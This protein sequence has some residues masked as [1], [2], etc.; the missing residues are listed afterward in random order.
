MCTNRLSYHRVNQETQLLIYF[1]NRLL[2]TRLAYQLA[3]LL[4]YF[5]NRPIVRVPTGSVTHLLHQQAH[6][7]TYFTN[8][9]SCSVLTPS[10]QL[11]LVFD[12]DD[13]EETEVS[14][15]SEMDSSMDLVDENEIVDAL[16][17]ENI[18]LV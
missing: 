3:Q 15:C 16:V 6:L 14:S 18:E 4:I 17:A 2:V 11:A 9:L 8:R 7:I 12:H 1:S 5:T 10:E 13:Q